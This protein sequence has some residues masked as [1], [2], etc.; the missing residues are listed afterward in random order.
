MVS[1][2]CSLKKDPS[3]GSKGGKQK[4]KRVLACEIKSIYVIVSGYLD[5]EAVFLV[6]LKR[7]KR[8]KEMCEYNKQTNKTNL[9]LQQSNK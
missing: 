2:N 1:Y 8:K 3:N 6:L 5:I 4:E 9:L 7:K